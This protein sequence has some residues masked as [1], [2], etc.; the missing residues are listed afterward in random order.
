MNGP[1]LLRKEMEFNKIRSQLDKKNQEL[2]RLE[3]KEF[4]SLCFEQPENYEKIAKM[5]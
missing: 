1:E 4:V 5:I 3:S 2:D